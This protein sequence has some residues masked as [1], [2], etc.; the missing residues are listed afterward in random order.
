MDLVS[1]REFLREL[2]LCIN[3]KISIHQ[4]PSQTN[5]NSKFD[6]FKQLRAVLC[7]MALMGL[8][9]IVGAFTIDGIS[10]LVFQYTFAITNI[11][12]VLLFGL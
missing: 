1:F 2:S 3:F 12:Q 9:W 8:T 6:G 10:G 7:L 4:P 5:T 11:S